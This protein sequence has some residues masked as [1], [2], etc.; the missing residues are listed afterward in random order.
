MLRGWVGRFSLEEARTLA[1]RICREN[2]WTFREPVRVLPGLFSWTIVTNGGMR[3]V[4]ARITVSRF[5]GQ[6][7]RAGYLKC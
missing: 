6:V 5:S 3:G 1:A 7:T 4:S 2:G